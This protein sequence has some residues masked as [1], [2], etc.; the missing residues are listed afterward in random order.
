MAFFR[1]RL[2]PAQRK[3]LGTRK[4]TASCRTH[5]H[6]SLVEV[7]A[8]HWDGGSRY[9]TARIDRDGQTRG[10][11]FPPV[12]WPKVGTARV[13]VTDSLGVIETGT[14]MGKTAAPALDV[15]EDFLYALL[16]ETHRESV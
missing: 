12:E 10:V 15:T 2:T 8:P 1:I 16:G 5:P 13:E 9:F 6:G 4:H 11:S 14:F 3:T 7:T